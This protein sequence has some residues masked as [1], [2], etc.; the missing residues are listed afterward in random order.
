MACKRQRSWIADALCRLD[1]DYAPV[2]DSEQDLAPPEALFPHG[3]G[4]SEDDT[5]FFPRCLFQ[6]MIFSH[7]PNEGVY[8]NQ[9]SLQGNV[10]CRAGW[11]CHE[12]LHQWN[13][14]RE[15]AVYPWCSACEHS[16]SGKRPSARRSLSVLIEGFSWQPEQVPWHW[17]SGRA[18]SPCSRRTDS[19]CDS[20]PDLKWDFGCGRK[21]LPSC[22]PTGTSANGTILATAPSPRAY[23]RSLPIR[24]SL[25]RVSTTDTNA[26]TK[27]PPLCRAK[28]QGTLTRSDTH[29]SPRC[30][31]RS[32]DHLLV[33]SVSAKASATAVLSCRRQPNPGK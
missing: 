14:I 11:L 4:S 2:D 5:P 21:L 20:E 16:S 25:L 32:T 23:P 1:S 33:L 12:E 10:L 27:E 13:P 8:P 22:T 26:L 31:A 3:G 15:L 17:S 29:P 30:A 24:S 18:D 6:E 28:H 19:I 7:S 9:P